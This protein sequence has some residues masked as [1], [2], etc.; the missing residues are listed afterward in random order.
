MK[1][2]FCLTILLAFVFST[3]CSNTTNPTN[4]KTDESTENPLLYYGFESWGKKHAITIQAGQIAGSLDL[5]DFPVLITLDH[6][7]SEVLDGGASSALNGGGDIRFSSD[8]NG[9]NQLAMEV[10][11]F[12]TDPTPANRRCQIWV[13]VPSLSASSD[14]TIYIWYN[15]VGEV[16]PAFDSA[17]GSQAVWSSYFF[18]SHDGRTDSAGGRAITDLPAGTET[19]PFGS[20]VSTYTGY[21]RA[22]SSVPDAEWD[23]VGV[24]LMC[25]AKYNSTG[26]WRRVV[27][28]I[29]TNVALQLVQGDG[30]E[31]DSFQLGAQT[32]MI[33]SGI[34]NANNSKVNA[35]SQETWNFY[36][37]AA[38]NADPN[39]VYNGAI[40]TNDSEDGLTNADTTQKAIFLG[41]RS[42]NNARF[43]GA[44]STIMIG[45]GSFTDEYFVTQ[46]NNQSSPATFATAG[47]PENV[48]GSGSGDT[49]APTAPTLS[50]TAQ[51]D[52]TADLSW[53]GA[54]DDTGVTGYN[55]F[56]DG[57]LETTLGNVG[58]YQVIGLTASTTYNFTVTAMDAAANQSAVSNITPVTTDASGGSSGGGGTWTEASGNLSYTTGNVGI[59]TSTIPTDYR[60]AV[61]GKIISEELKVQLQ[62]TWPDYVFKEGYDLP[63]LD[64][65]QK[66]IMENGHLPNI[67]AAK[68]VKKHGIEV[69][70]MNRLLL[71]KI[72][73][74]TLYVLQLKAENEKQQKEIEQLKLKE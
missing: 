18:V 37:G 3:V 41:G 20:Q 10:V 30:D 34:G 17:F 68:E 60:L 67:P 54:T 45:D 38:S 47:I 2:N 25:W 55:I 50:S 40:I 22:V 4:F 39:L 21:E 70:E 57:V 48:S 65:V 49:Q 56:K 24:S 61:S 28:I 72:E 29:N 69:G 12:V 43:D 19:G 36:A 16:Q 13:K 42:D 32:P 62:A 59:G 27:H 52:T 51:T 35:V 58:T 53:T 9:D 64:E 31:D 23:P 14:T 1:N 5:V 71:E 7:N 73:E 66:Y 44:I 8:V 26:S 6:L 33:T 11:E 15:K 63:S 74:L 46:Y